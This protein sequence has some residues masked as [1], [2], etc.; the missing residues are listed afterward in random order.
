M[1]ASNLESLWSSGF[2]RR[3]LLALALLLCC[4]L[5]P[6]LADAQDFTGLRGAVT[7]PSGLPVPA[8]S[9]KVTQE[10]SGFTKSTASNELGEYELRGILPGTYTM[11]V[12]V[13]GFK[14]YINQGV[15]VYSREVR[16][17]DVQLTIGEFTDSISVKE[18]GAVIQT[19]TSSIT[20]L[21]PRAEIYTVNSVTS[22][23]YS[24][25]NIAGFETRNQVRGLFANNMA[26]EQDGIPL[27]GWGVH[28]SSF[29]S[30]PEFLKEV[31]QSTVNASAEYRTATAVSGVGKSGQNRPHGE[32]FLNWNHPRLH[33]LPVNQRVRPAQ[34]P[35]EVFGSYEFGGP[36]YIPKVY[37]GKNKT[38]FYFVYQ[39]QTST[40]YS[41]VPFYVS[42][43]NKMRRGDLSEFAQFTG[44]PIIDPFTGQPF[45]NNQIPDA[46][47]SAIAK[48]TLKLVPEPNSGPAGALTNN[49]LFWNFDRSEDDWWQFRFD[50]Q[51]SE[52]DT[53]T[54]SFRRFDR[55]RRIYHMSHPFDGGNDGTH[56]GRFIGVQWSHTFSPTLLNEFSFA[57][58]RQRGEQN[59]GRASGRS[60]LQQELGITNLGGRQVPDSIGSPNIITQTVGYQFT[61]STA[62]AFNPQPSQLIGGHTSGYNAGDAGNLYQVRNNVS[63]HIKSHLFKTGVEYRLQKPEEIWIAGEAWGSY[64]FTGDF[65]GYD[66]ADFLLGLPYR[67]ALQGNRGRLRARH[68]ELGFFAQDD[69]KV[70]PKL[71]I[72]AGARFQHYG[73]PYAADG[74]YYNFDVAN[75]RIVVPDDKAVAA[76][77]PAYPKTI[78]VVT[79]AQAGYP[80]HLAEFKRLLVE[81]RIGLAWRPWSDKFVV[82]MGYGIY[83]TPFASP[84]AFATDRFLTGIFAPGLLWGRDGGPYRLREE[85]GP[86]Q[87]VGGQPLFTF[88][89]PFPTGPGRVGLQ[90]V[91]SQ[92]V[93][94]RKE[95]WPYDQQWNLTLERELPNGFAVRLSYVGSKGTHWPYVSNLQIPA[96]S[97]TPFTPARR[98]F[99]PDIYSSV[100]RF[101][102]GG[103]STY[104]GMDV[105]LTRQFSTGLYFR[106]WYEWKKTLNDVQGGLFGSTTGIETQDPYDR[107][108][109]K[110]YQDGFQPQRVRLMGVYD[111]PFGTG[112]RFLTNMP[113]WLNHVVRGWTIGEL[114]TISGKQR[115]TP[116]FT[117]RDTANIGRSGGRPDQLCNPNDFGP[118]PGLL[119]NRNCF[120]IPPNGR[121]GN[122]SR[123]MLSGPWIW[124]SDL[125]LFKTWYFTS[126]KQGAYMKLEMYADNVFNHSNTQGPNSLN[127]SSPGFGRF[128]V[129][130]SDYR[131]IYMRLRIGF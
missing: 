74:L 77:L 93:S 44:R 47:I 45:P 102:L 98:P 114:T 51:L 116:A 127:I 91:Y 100:F 34:K 112:K 83:H 52:R 129:T 72:T 18:Q 66:F 37:N 36:V 103:N 3:A 120:A 88:D 42:P 68:L 12:E 92:P 55:H 20:N 17:V 60:I 62:G 76:V 33:A 49:Y 90:T 65:T 56:E 99:G 27:Q 96:P 73:V 59:Q 97:T 106:G 119:W 31:R 4:L 61:P 105:E 89:R 23:V 104:H 110:G 118:S 13:R 32:A 50:H 113:G 63:Y 9:I 117:G 124:S 86:N 70:T 79:A 28:L 19:D 115:Y 101:D 111:L 7:D 41:L 80:E 125:R 107:R 108:S 25:G 21:Q 6:P 87:I 131:R 10:G 85:F 38:F 5:I 67:T 130:P 57:R 26:T 58:T 24:V 16:R 8:A 81:P 94:S 53:F 69:W 82:R 122:S 14:K 30:P 64:T 71:T 29:K 95:N 1:K 121:F 40:V 43:T 39:P 2:S 11:E 46:R 109:D 75:R 128:D 126:D 48:N 54:V 22:L 78:S 35:Q 15:I 84:T 123:G